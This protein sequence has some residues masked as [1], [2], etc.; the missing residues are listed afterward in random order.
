MVNKHDF[1]V[2]YLGGGKQ[3]SIIE[4]TQATDNRR[5]INECT[6]EALSNQLEFGIK[7]D[8][9]DCITENESK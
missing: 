3:T 7:E 5:N 9:I 2:G 6:R 8:V 4:L 1:Y